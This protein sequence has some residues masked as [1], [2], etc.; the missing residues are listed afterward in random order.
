[1]KENTWVRGSNTAWYDSR[2]SP[3]KCS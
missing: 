3:A 1:M 2:V